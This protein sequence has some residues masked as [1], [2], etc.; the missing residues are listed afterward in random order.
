MEVQTVFHCRITIYLHTA[1]L[2]FT[3]G[4][5]FAST[6]LWLLIHHATKRRRVVMGEAHSVCDKC[7]DPAESAGTLTRPAYGREGVGDRK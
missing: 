3:S 6:T 7:V 5:A 2:G 4:R 1:R